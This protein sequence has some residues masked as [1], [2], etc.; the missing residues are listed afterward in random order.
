MG[1]VGAVGESKPKKNL[2]RCI[3]CDIV[4]LCGMRL[5]S[6]M[7]GIAVCDWMLTCRADAVR[8]RDTIGRPVATLPPT[9]KRSGFK[10]WATDERVGGFQIT[11]GEEAPLR[12][13]LSEL[14][15]LDAPAET[16]ADDGRKVLRKPARA[17]GSNDSRFVEG[18]AC[19]TGVVQEGLDVVVR[20]GQASLLLRDALRRP[21]AEITLGAVEASLRRP[22]P[23]VLQAYCG[24]HIAAWTFNPYISA[25][26]PLLESWDLILSLDSNSAAEVHTCK[27]QDSSSTACSAV[28]LPAGPECLLM[29]HDLKGGHISQHSREVVVTHV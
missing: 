8:A 25:W 27:P 5:D 3:R 2:V 10:V 18:A 20:T 19:G 14:R 7:R 13:S 21:L 22:V 12:S 17:W 9:P 28:L 26:E 23:N 16:P 6:K 24:V 4:L 1:C 29:M 11:R 15:V